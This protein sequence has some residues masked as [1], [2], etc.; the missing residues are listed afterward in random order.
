MSRGACVRHARVR[1]ERGLNTHKHRGA[2]QLSWGTRAGFQE[3]VAPEGRVCIS[4]G[5]KQAHELT[6]EQQGGWS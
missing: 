5:R 4:W 1:G 3:E 2:S 6:G